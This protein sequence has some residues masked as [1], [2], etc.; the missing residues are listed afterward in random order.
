MQHVTLGASRRKLRTDFFV[1]FAIFLCL[2]ESFKGLGCISYNALLF[3]GFWNWRWL[4]EEENARIFARLTEGKGKS[5][6]V[7]LPGLLSPSASFFFATRKPVLPF[8]RSLFSKQEGEFNLI[9]CRSFLV[10]VAAAA[11]GFHY[12]RCLSRM[13]G[14]H[15]TIPAYTLG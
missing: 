3:T 6:C 2:V 4:R 9:K 14:F 7:P 1:L 15:R 13:T 10:F 12:P 5:C 11:R 8:L